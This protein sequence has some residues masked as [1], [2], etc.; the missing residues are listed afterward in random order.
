MKTVPLKI[1]VIIIFVA[2]VL[3]SYGQDLILDVLYENTPEPNGITLPEE[4]FDGGRVKNVSKAQIYV[5]LPEK[6]ENTKTA[7]LICPGGGYVREAIE[8]EG[9][10]YARFLE[11]H[12]IAGIVLKYRLP[13]GHSKVPM[14]DAKNAMRM[15]RAN[16]EKWGID[17]T[18]I[19]I[20]GSS[21]GGH[22]ASTVGT[23]F[24]NG[25]KDATQEFARYSCRPDFMVLMYPLICVRESIGRP[26]SR[27]A[28][29]G[30][31]YGEADIKYFSNQEHVTAETPPTF[32]CHADDDKVVTP[33]NSILFYQALKKFEI[34]AE[35]HIF[36]KGDHGFGMTK[37]NLPVD[38][39]PN[40]VIDWLK[41]M[42][43]IED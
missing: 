34:P 31:N 32:L 3:N 16:A 35:L 27:H 28:L 8:N 12:G 1:I 25:N 4:V 11:E 43:F 22:L 13:N 37:A 9:H 41:S 15:V 7:V 17:P 40:L 33:T 39:W 24:D 10:K 30:E 21:A 38:N 14:L 5:Y 29:L 19:G 2:G 20:S 26:G 36:H 23:H 42:N 6:S 18:K